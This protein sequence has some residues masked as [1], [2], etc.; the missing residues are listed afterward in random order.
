M[1]AVY[2][3][4]V[5]GENPLANLTVGEL[6]VPVPRPGWALIRVR[7]AS[8]NHHDIWT[9]RGVSS[10]PVTPPHILGCDAAGEVEAYGS[11]APS[12]APAVGA[13]VVVYPIVTC[14]HCAACLADEPLS[15]RSFRMLS[16]GSLAGGLAEYVE[17][18]AANLVALPDQVSFADAACLPTAYLTAYRA[19]FVRAGLRP[20]MSVLVQGASGGVA[21]ACILLG[22][23]AGITVYATSR[24]EAKRA[25][26]ADLGAEAAFPVERETARAVIG[27]TGGVG[28]DAVVDT[29]GEP[30]WDLSLRA[31]KPG[32][33]VVVPG[34]TGGANPPAQLN[35]IFF[36]SVTIAGTTMG[37]RGE[38]RRLVDL[39]ATGALR[40]LVGSTH[41]L[42]DAAAA[43]AE[44]AAGD[45]RGKII[46]E[47]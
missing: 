15:C 22:R 31:V 12:G 32:G 23:L 5:G 33:V 37:T 4:A 44:M 6:P 26:A 14:G 21:T 10:A 19:L 9:L 30:T 28:V 27:A 40:P 39:I 2:A 7:A 36:R 11:E 20:G 24:D 43:F 25:L 46:L 13:R 29:V 35:R 18:P 34:A 1:L 42:R 47:A 41:A 8:L 3:S 17:I 45:L 16:E 38:L